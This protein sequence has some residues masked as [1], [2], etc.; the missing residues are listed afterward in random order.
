MHHWVKSGLKN[1]LHVNKG[2]GGKE[3]RRKHFY[4]CLVGSSTSCGEPLEYNRKNKGLT[5]IGTGR[6]GSKRFAL[7][8]ASALAMHK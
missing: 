3:K 7:N 5:I 4:V 2:R 8:S 6:T 1:V